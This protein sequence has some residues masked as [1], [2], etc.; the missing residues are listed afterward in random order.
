MQLGPAKEVK[1]AATK[2]ACCLA[3]AWRLAAVKKR[4]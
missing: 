2:K 3:A 4:I 1:L